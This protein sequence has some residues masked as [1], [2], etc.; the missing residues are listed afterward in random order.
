[1]GRPRW[2]AG[3]AERSQEARSEAT[4]LPAIASEPVLPT[5]APVVVK[6]H[7]PLLKKSVSHASVPSAAQLLWRRRDEEHQAALTA[8]RR[9][10]PPA[11]A[12][13]V[14]SPQ[15]T[16][17]Q[18]QVPATFPGN[19]RRSRLSSAVGES[20]S[21][22]ERR[23]RRNSMDWDSPVVSACGHGRGS[24]VKRMSAAAAG[25]T[26]PS[27]DASSEA[28]RIGAAPAPAPAGAPGE[29]T[30]AP[31]LLTQIGARVRADVV[32]EMALVR[33]RHC[34]A[35]WHRLLGMWW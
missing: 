1:M 7:F 22:N 15:R 32:D 12:L 21:A 25:G 17:K 31:S 27:V 13:H 3:R 10:P 35:A 19:E 23:S 29:E 2:D 5:R 8:A 34:A 18:Q 6:D 11:S 14:R 20:P 26:P 30:S 4:T 9:R 24:F 16:P 33:C 28:Q